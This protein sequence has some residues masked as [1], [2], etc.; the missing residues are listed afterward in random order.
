M[1]LKERRGHHTWYIITF[2]F[3]KHSSIISKRGQSFHGQNFQSNQ[4]QANSEKQNH[5]QSMFCPTAVSLHPESYA[6]YFLQAQKPDVSARFPNDWVKKVRGQA[7]RAH[8]GGVHSSDTDIW[9]S[10]VY[11]KKKRCLLH[12]RISFNLLL[13]SS[14]RSPVTFF[15]AHSKSLESA[16]ELAARHTHFI[17]CNCWWDF[18]VVMCS[19]VIQE[20]TGGKIIHMY[21]ASPYE[22]QNYQ[23]ISNQIWSFTFHK[24]CIS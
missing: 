12:S 9:F 24:H 8:H 1:W 14:Y 6:E 18:L 13:V 21:K 11:I 10:N 5:L 17:T 23:Q 7:S 19:P 16:L 3:A 22:N 20:N 4:W 2:Y 15:V